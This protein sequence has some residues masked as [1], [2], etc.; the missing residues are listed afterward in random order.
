MGCA[1]NVRMVL[2][3]LN[4]CFFSVIKRSLFGNF[5]QSLGMAYFMP[6]T[7]LSWNKGKLTKGKNFSTDMRL[8]PV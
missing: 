2:Q 1:R 7:L 8:Q 3:Q 4:M 6:L 5:L